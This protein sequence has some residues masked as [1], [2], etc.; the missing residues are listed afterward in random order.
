[1]TL[2]VLDVHFLYKSVISLI[3]KMSENEEILEIYS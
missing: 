1:M 2:A 3:T